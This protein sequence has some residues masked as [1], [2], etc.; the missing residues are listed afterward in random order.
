MIRCDGTVRL[1]AVFQVVRSLPGWDRIV[2]VSSS[3]GKLMD[4]NT[5]LTKHDGMVRLVVSIV[6]HRSPLEVLDRTLTCL[7]AALREV[8][9]KQVGGVEVVVVDNASGAAYTTALR[10]LVGRWRAAGLPISLRCCRHN[11]GYGRG[12]NLVATAAPDFR[13]VLNPDVFLQSNA[14]V[15]GLSFLEEHA[16]VGLVVPR[17]LG[18]ESEP[19]Y[20][21]KR[22]PTLLAL[23]LRGFAPAGLRRRY[24]ACLAHYEMRDLDW[25]VPR[26]DLELVSGCCLLMRG[27]VWQRTGGFDPGYFLY[28]ED[29]DFALRVREHFRIAYV[30]DFVVTHLG[31]EAARKG[32]RHRR[33]FI[34]SA[35]RFFSGHGWRWC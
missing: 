30:P 15:Q 12:H 3:F 8:Q 2:E 13:L 20:L 31:G 25:D 17:A 35:W 29:F 34:Q 18:K 10:T 11:L 33:W 9:G 19:L 1:F 14:L 7:Q 26:F 16:E 21:C 23:A 24:A 22:Y 6:L 4:E 5:G 32:W 27:E 28:F